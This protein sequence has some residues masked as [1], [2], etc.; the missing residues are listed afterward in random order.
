MWASKSDPKYKEK[1][2]IPIYADAFIG[3]NLEFSIS[4]QNFEIRKVN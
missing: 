1:V 2:N 4:D 3:N